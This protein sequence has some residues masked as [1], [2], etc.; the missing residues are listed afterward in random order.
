MIQDAL[1]IFKK[2]GHEHLVARCL[3]NFAELKYY[4]QETFEAKRHIDEALN[5]VKRLDD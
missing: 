3:R 5:I 4:L 1:M 2:C